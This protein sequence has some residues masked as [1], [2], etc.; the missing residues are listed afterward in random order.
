M[1]TMVILSKAYD[2]SDPEL[3][4]WYRLSHDETGATIIPLQP[5][6]QFQIKWITC[7]GAPKFALLL[8]IWVNIWT[9][10]CSNPESMFQKCFLDFHI[11]SSRS[12]FVGMI[13]WVYWKPSRGERRVQAEVS[14]GSPRTQIRAR[15]RVQMN[16]SLEDARCRGPRICW[17]AGY[18]TLSPTGW[19]LSKQTEW[20]RNRP[21]SEE[22]QAFRVSLQRTVPWGLQ[23]GSRQWVMP[24]RTALGCLDILLK[25]G[26]EPL[27][28]LRKE[29][30]HGQTT[31]TGA[32]RVHQRDWHQ[33]PEVTGASLM[34]KYGAYGSSSMER[35]DIG[36][37][38]EEG[39][40]TGVGD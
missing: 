14:T 3:I 5:R 35:K 2:V 40:S 10:A 26:K 6:K 11:A 19:E 7:P 18:P 30:Q 32:P 24:L 33:A 21:G 23:A 39:N 37:Q 36:W 27:K 38:R 1:A 34:Q 17:W 4:T 25:A 31:T 22:V 12:C 16:S 20:E 8:S 9:P 13:P 28:C 15:C 29:G